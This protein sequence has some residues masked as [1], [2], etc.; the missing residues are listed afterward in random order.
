M[1]KRQSRSQLKSCKGSKSKSI[2][3]WSTGPQA[4]RKTIF[5]LNSIERLEDRLVMSADPIGIPSMGHHTLGDSIE[6]AIFDSST[7]HNPQADFWLDQELLSAEADLGERIEQSLYEAHALAGQDE[8]VSKYGFEGSGQTVV[9][10]DSGIAYEHDALGAGYGD[11]YRVVGGWDFAENDADPYDDGSAGG[12]GTHVA[13]IIGAQG[14]SNHS[15]VA[16]GVDLVGLRVFDD[17]GN[18]YFSW[19]EDALQW[20]YDNRNAFENE[21]TTVNLSLGTSWNS[22]SI[23]AWAM[24]EEEFAQL[25]SVGIFV[26][27]SAGNSYTSYNE[28]GLSYPAASDHVIPVMSVD[29]SGNLSYF[30]QRAEYAI[31][32][33]GRGITSTLPDYTGN[34]SNNL[35]D[36]WGAMSGTSMAAPYVAGASVLIREAMEF[37][38]LTDIDQWEIYDV[39]MA[40]ADNFY[41][42]SSQAYYKRLNIE[43]AIDAIMPA[44]DFGSSVDT[45]HHL[46]TIPATGQT[47]TLST[48]S[49]AITTLSDADYFSFTAGAT[50]IATFTTIAATHALVTDWGAWGSDD[51]DA[52]GWDVDNGYA[53]SV[54]AGETYSVALSSADGLGYYDFNISLEESFTAVD[55]GSVNS[56]ETLEELSLVGEEWYR[57]TADRMGY[58]TVEA[59]PASGSAQIAIYDSHLNLID[60]GGSAGRVDAL[61]NSGETIYVQL[62]GD[63]SDLDLRLT[64]AVSVVGTTISVAGTSGDDSIHFEAGSSEHTLTFNEIMYRFS[65][66]SHD[67]FHIDGKGG[68]DTATLHGTTGDDVLNANA[69]K[70][71][72]AGDAYQITIND[73]S[74]VLVEGQGGQDTANLYGSD[75]SDRAEIGKHYGLLQSTEAGYFNSAKGFR[76]VNVYAGVGGSNVAVIN[77]TTTADLVSLSANQSVMTDTD[78]SYASL[79][80][81]FEVVYAYSNGGDDIVSQYDG[82]TNDQFIGTKSYSLLRSITGEFSNY[83]FGFKTTKAYSANGGN[84]LA[85]LYDSAADDIAEFGSDYG[86]LGSTDGSF[87]NRAEGFSRVLAY[88]FF[89]GNDSVIFHDSAGDDRFYGLPEYAMMFDATGSYSNLALGFES[90]E[91]VSNNGGH[92]QAFLYDSENDD[93]FTASPT[94]AKM[95]DGSKYQNVVTGFGSVT[96][97]ARGG[98][99]TAILSD[100]NADDRYVVGADFAIM[101]DVSNSYTNTA[102]GFENTQG[103][104]SHGGFDQATLFDSRADDTFTWSAS[105]AIM[106][107]KASTYRN[108]ATGFDKVNAFAT[109]GGNDTAVLSGS[110]G[111]DYGYASGSTARLISPTATGIA[112]GF[113]DI[114]LDDGSDG[115]DQLDVEVVDYAFAT[116]G[117]WD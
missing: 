1:S 86:Q 46:G 105:T 57:L 88:A 2:R 51:Q 117:D 22:D 34:D 71:T 37:T 67:E 90:V 55:L 49:G 81:G 89:G 97:Y 9:V 102:I 53:M 100:S 83:A 41:D 36:E 80:N 14:E 8:A 76:D 73:F 32:A 77:G 60:A 98:N 66:E 68:N 82:N 61:V 16:T 10:I 6:Q 5:R 101:K 65:A 4:V 21:I 45:A 56:Q 94:T 43:A 27:V 78:A 110:T 92:D 3:A 23:P 7:Y 54:I 115:N 58:F 15:G 116:V 99:D 47:A 109:N 17:A 93:T 44:D 63:S 48:L 79:A 52:R 64:N 96:A 26:S 103:I 29:N 18:G 108:E 95:T 40:T 106:K 69:T 85:F 24:L 19:V 35:D 13:G 38:G 107:D 104:S 113:N 114:T 62:T 28:Q 91:A 33:P 70:A 25:E 30:S 50:G 39:M 74:S 20:V 12:H 87:L 112:N 75:S 59:L 72:L 42:A 84:D 31:A 111:N 11:G